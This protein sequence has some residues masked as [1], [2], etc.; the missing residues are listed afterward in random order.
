VSTH[1][2]ALGRRALIIAFII[3]LVMMSVDLWY[4]L[5]MKSASLLG[6]AANNS[7]DVFILGSS[8]LVIS[9]TTAVKNRLALFKG[10]IMMVFGLWAF[11]H[12]Y[13][14]LIEK[15]DLTGGTIS[16]IGVL[17]LAGNTSVAFM[18]YKHQHKDINFMSA[19]I[20]C[21]ND[22]IASAGII[23]AGLLVMFTGDIWP[24]IV[25]GTAIAIIVS[26]G[27]IKII[28]L[29]LDPTTPVKDDC[30]DDDCC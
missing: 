28:R 17:S 30:C 26:H 27:G 15:S 1:A 22:A 11:Y 21:R 14:G 13:L 16:L 9:S 7:G 20:C 10:I 5:M 29:S 2:D 12:V 24:D 23:L 4:G 25:I 3:N 8:I 19:F 6:D 18:M